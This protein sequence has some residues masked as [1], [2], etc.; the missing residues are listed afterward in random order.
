MEPLKMTVKTANE[1]YAAL[2]NVDTYP[3]LL[4]GEDGKEKVVNLPYKLSGKARWNFTK[5]TNRL[6]AH[7]ADF[8]KNRDDIIKEVSGGT[9][10]IQQTDTVKMQELTRK[11]EEL[12]AQE[13]DTSGI[14][15]VS[16]KD[17]NL[18]PESPIP[19]AVLSL[20][21]PILDDS[22]EPIS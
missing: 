9:G 16:V 11:V 7:D 18:G 13:V 5:A 22:E 14:L 20:L 21:T 12:L 17:L 6:R 3:H 8:T 2:Q 15:R 4:K 10:I 19:V 1:V